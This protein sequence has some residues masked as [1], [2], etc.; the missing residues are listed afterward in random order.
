MTMQSLHLM[1]PEETYA[2]TRMDRRAAF[3]LATS[4]LFGKTLES[5]N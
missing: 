2:V 1:V 4:K 3:K 5:Q